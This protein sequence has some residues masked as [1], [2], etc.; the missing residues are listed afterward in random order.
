[1]SAQVLRM[2]FGLI[3]GRDRTLGEIGEELGVSR[4]RVRQIEAEALAK[5]RQPKLRQKLREYLE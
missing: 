2:R 5:L 3:D 4:E 1:M